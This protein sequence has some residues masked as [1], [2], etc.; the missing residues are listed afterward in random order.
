MKRYTVGFI[1]NADLSRVA[2][3]TKSH[4]DWQKGKQNGIGGK[5]EENETPI[6]CMV[7]E[8][9]EEAGIETKESDWL[10]FI[11]LERKSNDASVDF[12]AYRHTGDGGDVKTMTD[13]VVSWYDVK[14]LPTTVVSNLRFMIPMAIEKLNDPNL[15]SG[16]VH[17]A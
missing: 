14:E 11:N 8:A 4:P 7:R 10:Y 15:E 12:F 1:F 16:T 2:L 17:Y 9:H 3:E 13:E 6:A 5:I